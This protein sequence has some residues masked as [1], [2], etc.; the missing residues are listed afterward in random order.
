MTGEYFSD[1][2]FFSHSSV[3]ICLHK[4]NLDI[5]SL[6][7]HIIKITIIFKTSFNVALKVTLVCSF[8]LRFFFF[9]KSH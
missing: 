8:I 4:N 3:D 1:E 6:S 9:N 7:E 5:Q 2:E